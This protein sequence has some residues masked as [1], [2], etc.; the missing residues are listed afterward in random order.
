MLLRFISEKLM[1]PTPAHHPLNRG[2]LYRIFDE[3]V[4]E[5]CHAWIRNQNFNSTPASFKKFEDELFPSI[6]IAKEKS[7]TLMTAIRCK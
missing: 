4:A 2:S 1:K 7:I 5:K 3:D 6:G